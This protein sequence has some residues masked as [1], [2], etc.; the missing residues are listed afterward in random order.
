METKKLQETEI[1]QLRLIQQKNQDILL[2][3]GQIELIKLELKSRVQNA[4]AFLEELREEE[5]T[6]SEYLQ[7]TYGK[8]SVNLDKGEFTPFE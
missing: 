2:E 3:F 5:K 6:L 7:S 8:G 1:Q 4:K